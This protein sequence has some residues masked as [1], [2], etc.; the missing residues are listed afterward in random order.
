MCSGERGLL[1]SGGTLWL[2]SPTLA[3]VDH[4]HRLSPPQ[5][6]ARKDILCTIYGLSFVQQFKWGKPSFFLPS[7]PQLQCLPSEMTF[8]P[9]SHGTDDYLQCFQASLALLYILAL[10]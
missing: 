1:L 8:Q 6:I 2:S 9:P 4:G 5:I 10:G 7:L 3:A